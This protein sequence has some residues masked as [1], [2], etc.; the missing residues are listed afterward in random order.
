MPSEGKPILYVFYGDYKTKENDAL[1]EHETVH[2]DRKRLK[3]A[4]SGVMGS[5]GCPNWYKP[6]EISDR[7]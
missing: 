1:G 4:R 2:E 5:F 3:D 6:A 7:L